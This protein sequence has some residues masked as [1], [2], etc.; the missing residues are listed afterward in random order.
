MERQK[1]LAAR[2]RTADASASVLPPPLSLLALPPRRATALRLR[3]SRVNTASTT[4]RSAENPCT[5]FSQRSAR[6]AS[7]TSRSIWRG[8]AVG[9]FSG[10]EGSGARVRER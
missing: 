9:P 5:H 4:A 6:S 7:V 2:S 3:F 8:G 1:L 10:W